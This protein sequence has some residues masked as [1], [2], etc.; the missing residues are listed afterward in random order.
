MSHVGAGY[1]VYI[2][3]KEEITGSIKLSQNATVFQAEIIAIKEAVKTYIQEKKDEYQFIKI[4][5]D[6]QAAFHALASTTYTSKVVKETILEL[7]K[8]GE[9]VTRVEVTWIK[10]H[11][12]HK[13]NERAD[14]LARQAN[15]IEDIDFHIADS[16]TEYKSKLLSSIVAPI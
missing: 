16:W 9:M 1:V 12:G 15:D 3:A 11:A 4:I 13:G 5:T 2:N 14:E 7:N 8:L 10:A 6:S